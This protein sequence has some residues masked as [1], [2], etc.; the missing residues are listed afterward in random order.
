[1]EPS[2]CT[3]PEDPTFR[4]FDAFGLPPRLSTLSPVTMGAMPAAGPPPARNTG[5]IGRPLH[6]RVL[7]SRRMTAPLKSIEGTGDIAATLAEIGRRARAAARVL[8]LAPTQQ[9]DRALAGM[10]KAIRAA[11][12]RILAAN[13]EV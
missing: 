11:T 4:R 6:A 8:A 10:A 13:A 12:A 9:K 7:G 2:S 5:V 1:M 3:H